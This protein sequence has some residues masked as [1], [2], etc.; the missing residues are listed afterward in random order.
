MAFTIGLVEPF[1]WPSEWNQLHVVLVGD[2]FRAAAT[3]PHAAVPRVASAAITSA[4]AAGALIQ[5]SGSASDPFI[6]LP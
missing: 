3:V 4:R 1:S 6:S 2:A 5:I